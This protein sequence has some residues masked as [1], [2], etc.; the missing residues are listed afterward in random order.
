M[1]DPPTIRGA[2]SDAHH[3]TILETLARRFPTAKRQTLRRML[4]DGRVRVN[5]ERANRATQV[6]D[7]SA[8]IIVAPA[9]SASKAVNSALPRSLLAP[10]RLVHEDDDLLVI[11]KPAGLLTSTV[12]REKRPTALAKVRAYTAATSPRSRVGLIHRLDRDASGLLVF[13]K[14]HQ[15]Y[16]SL[17]SQF[18][19]HTV[20]RIYEA[21]VRGSVSPKQGRI[22]AHLIERADGTVRI[23]TPTEVA[24][25]KGQ[26]AITDYELLSRQAGQSKLR[27]RLQTGRKHQ[28]RVHLS[29]RG[30]P[31][32][33]D[34]VY[35]AKTAS[36]Q[37]PL[38]L[39]A[40]VLSFDH[41]RTGR[42]MSFG[43]S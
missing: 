41:P 8:E 27:I 18:F 24:K 11:D 6:V 23:A 36:P 35:D 10:L 5:G 33:G 19:H 1:P 14:T 42:R 26:R 30:W 28:I 17:K 7:A 2:V 9:S 16:Q 13:S 38:L 25:H 22:D 20:E 21:T 39:R 32:V 43:A 15:A 29:H 12:A 40:V 37:S 31:I 3:I 4:A 34:R